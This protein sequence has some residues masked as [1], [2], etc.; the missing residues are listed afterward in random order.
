MKELFLLLALTLSP[1]AQ[2]YSEADYKALWSKAES[3]IQE[4][5]PQ[6]AVG[7]LSE[8]EKMCLARQ[9]TLEQYK[10]MRCKY[11]CLS[12]YNW[13]EANS[14]YPSF[15][16]LQKQLTGNLD[17]YIEKYANHPAVDWLVCEKIRK[18]KR[19]VDASRDRSGKRYREIRKMC[20]K[21]AE[22][23]PESS[24][25]EEFLQIVRNMDAKQTE[26][27]SEKRF[28]Y[29]G[30]TVEFEIFCRNIDESDFL[31]YRLNDR[32]N[33]ITDDPLKHISGNA[34]LVSKQ[35]LSSYKAEYNMKEKVTADFTFK[36]PGIY[37]VANSSDD[38]SGHVI[39]YVSRVAFASRQADG[40]NE[41]YVADGLTGKPFPGATIYAW[42][43]NSESDGNQNATFVAPGLISSK[44]YALN[45]FTRLNQEIF[46]KDKRMVPISA[47]VGDD[48]WCPALDI[49][50]ASNEKE[51]RSNETIHYI[52]TDRTL[53][54]TSDTIFFKLIALFRL[55]ND[56]N[57]LSRQRQSVGYPNGTMGRGVHTDL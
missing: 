45:G 15:S 35:H 16:A 30:Q 18:I 21:A 12:K 28:V 49:I 6:T 3:A 52:Y 47:Q 26:V 43:E 17:Y 8:L 37:L 57:V 42:S 51:R 48:K 40:G 25:R 33:I 19:E 24:Y 56:A 14:Y 38:K 2:V 39:V 31:V 44:E 10:V 5:K 13:K 22:V 27:R 7:Y 54:R 32:Y 1:N 53:Y 55:D 23:F 34:R 50:K 29:P 9:D 46:S 4:G 20:M 11:E 36:D 41:V